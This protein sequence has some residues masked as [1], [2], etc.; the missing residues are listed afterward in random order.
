M[1]FFPAIVA[2]TL[3]LRALLLELPVGILFN[4]GGSRPFYLIGMVGFPLVLFESV[5]RAL[6]FLFLRQAPEIVV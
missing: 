1:F 4:Y 3:S 5:F 6:A 2:F